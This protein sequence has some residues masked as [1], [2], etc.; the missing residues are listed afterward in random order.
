MSAPD[1]VHGMLTVLF[2]GAALHALTNGVLSPSSGWRSRIDHLLHVVMALAMAAM[3]WGLVLPEAEQTAFFLAAALWFL[4]TAD[5]GRHGFELAAIARRLP[6]AV[7]MAA[8][9]WMVGLSHATAGGSHQIQAGG[10]PAAHPSAHLDRP[11]GESGAGDAVTAVLA[12]WLLAYAFRSLTVDMPTLR[13]TAK[14]V[15]ASMPGEPYRNFWD[16]SV[17]LGTA[18]MLLM[19]H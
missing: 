4:L 13:S 10:L 3:P 17:A 16:G 8:M 15:H 11:L 6:Y 12:V 2:L 14:T 1:V 7:G 19:P 9:A 5:R 18:V